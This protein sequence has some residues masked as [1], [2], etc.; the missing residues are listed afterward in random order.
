MD[1]LSSLDQL[2]KKALLERCHQLQSA[3]AERE[4]T[5]TSWIQ[6]L[7][8][9]A[10]AD[11][12]MGR[13]LT[14]GLQ[15]ILKASHMDVGYI[16]LIDQKKHTLRLRACLGLS[17]REE[18]ELKTIREGE[19][20]PG[21]VLQK[22][23]AMISS[24]V[25]EISDLSGSVTRDR[26]RMLHAGFPLKWNGRVIGTLT[27]LSKN[28]KTL[29]DEDV[30]LLRAFSQ[31][32]AVVVQNL[33]LFDIVSRGKSQWENAIDFVPD[34]IFVCD[35][36]FRIIKTNRAIIDRFWLPLEDA[37]GK[38][39]F[40]LLYE[41][42]PFPVSRKNLERMLGQGITYYE[43]VA[44]PRWGGVFSVIVSPILTFGRLSGSVHVIKEITNERL[45]EEDRDELA[46]KVSLLAPG[47]ITADP[48]GS[49]RS[50]DSGA[51]EILGYDEKEM[52]AKPLS[53]I[54]S[55]PESETLFN[56]L[57]QRDGILDFDTIAIAKGGRSV[58][59][60][61]TLSARRDE[62]KR[63]KEISIFIRDMS[64]R[65]E[66]KMRL[67]HATRLTAMIET[68]ANV[69]RKL[70]E[71]L[72]TLVAQI[73]RIED[74]VHEPQEITTRLKRVVAH[75][76]SVQEVLDRLRQFSEIHPE[77]NLRRLES[78]R[79]IEDIVK[80][81]EEKWSD[82]FRTRGID[83]QINPDQRALPP[84]RGNLQDLLA[85]FDHLIR[86]AVEAM[87]NG[88]KLILRTRTDRKWVRLILIDHGVGMNRE[89]INRAFDPFFTT[90]PQN[91][92]LGLSIAHG[93]IRTHQGE[94]GLQSV[95][96]QGTRVT[97]KLPAVPE[98]SKKE[99][100][101]SPP[102]RSTSKAQS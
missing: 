11:Q 35:R 73:D 10:P 49:I 15:H 101:T 69:R 20:V 51:S 19:K 14:R 45:L 62:D 63:L 94:V 8:G 91:L 84:I 38:E 29:S 77:G 71:K 90:H 27:V 68:A 92:G 1:G 7:T 74:G 81:I 46:R 43:E 23:D 65:S 22:A 33:S 36:D 3:L 86:N 53:M 40:D 88:G 55:S 48:E 18:E 59:V 97:V 37:L 89:E 30:A 102:R 93:L 66:D 6:A 54:L 42:N 41:G 16:H 34:L 61:L 57:K 70:G 39:C 13:S 17:K 44:T 75:A 79:L 28:R 32:T 95:P 100:P 58:P 26:K 83:F 21:Q 50:C 2:D 67:V 5:A 4:G 80:M 64:H 72:D 12:G 85:V 99:P 31:F 24:S 98:K 52:R 82:P 25:T 96:G 9:I 60:S 47:T 56:G 87:A 76:R 78:S